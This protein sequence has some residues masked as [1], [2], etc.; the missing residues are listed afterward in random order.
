MRR[1]FTQVAS[2]GGAAL[3]L[4]AAWGSV[5]AGA[6]PA[7]P[8]PI[9]VEI[10]DQYGPVAPTEA[11]W[12]IAN[13]L[14]PEGAVTVQQMM[15]ALLRA[16]P[17]AFFHNNV[18]W[19][20]RG[21]I[22]R[23]PAAS[24]LRALSA[25][26]ALLAIKSQNDLWR[27]VNG[28]LPGVEPERLAAPS[29]DLVE[30]AQAAAPQPVAVAEVD[31]EQ[32]SAAGGGLGPPAR[33]EGV[34]EP[35]GESAQ[36]PAEGAASPL[37]GGAEPAPAAET[38]DPPPAEPVRKE[39]PVPV[40]AS[41]PAKTA[42]KDEEGVS[43]WV[44]ENATAVARGVSEFAQDW[45]PEEVWE[46]WLSEEAWADRLN[47]LPVELPENLAAS[48]VLAGLVL[49]L[50]L[51]LWWLW[52]RRSAARRRNSAKRM[53]PAIGSRRPVAQR[54][55]R[56]APPPQ[57][58]GAAETDDMARNKLDLA[59]AYIAL[60]DKEQAKAALQEVLTEGNPAQQKEARVLLAQLGQ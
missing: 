36:G 32:G 53:G 25:R 48:V 57:S 54:A 23:L 3:L 24:E 30:A 15:M 45:L 41:T 27:A 42:A 33:S 46:D 21:H 31:P 40:V 37:A 59:K 26:E 20:K 52:P 29:A 9:V 12:S 39:E 14:R 1:T 43:A 17:N 55:R 5:P 44:V 2:L 34:G 7:R 18:N 10:G 60:G 51:I 11:L 56:Q 58:A 50:L 13:R 6:A 28:V 4:L 35:P 49:F 22:L 38:Q 8:G 16:N 19:L 47:W